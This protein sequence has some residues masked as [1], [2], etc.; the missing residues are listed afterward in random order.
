MRA[1]LWRLCLALL[2]TAAP[3][4][5]QEQRGS[6]EG[7]V[8]DSSG[9]VLPGVTVEAR[10]TTSGGAQTAV[11]DENGIY[12]FAA[13]APGLYDVRASLDSFNPAENKGVRLE[14]GQLLRVNLSLAVKGVQESVQVSAEQPLIDVKQNAKATVVDST[15]IDKMPTGRNFPDVVFAAAGAQDEDRAG[16]IQIDGASGSENRFMIDGLDTTNLQTGVSGK[17]LR[18]DFVQEVQVKTSGYNAE[19]RAAT[20]GVISA[21]TKSGSNQWHGGAS[22]YF[23]DADWF[24]DVR[25]TLRLN[26]IDTRQAETVFIPADDHTDSE[27][28]FDIGGPIFRDRA[29]FFLGGYQFNNI[30]KRTVRFTQRNPNNESRT[31]E[32][33]DRTNNYLGNISTQLTNELRGKF[34]FNVGR[35]RNGLALPGI[36]PNGTST[37][38]PD[39]FP[40]TKHLESYN[41][42]YSGTLDWV[43]SSKLYFNVTA[44]YNRYGDEEQGLFGTTLRREFASDNSMFPEI[45]ANLRQPNGYA[46]A[47]DV[48]RISADNWSRWQF[49]S[50]ATYY[51]NWMGQHTL[52]GGVQY[53]RITNDVNRG[54][55]FPRIILNWN[56]AFQSFDQGPL[57]GPYGHYTVRV[58]TTV[59]QITG[60]NVA[61]FIQDGW[62]VND[63]LTMN[64]GLRIEKEEVPSYRPENPGI[65][66]GWGDKITPRVGF[67]YDL[68]GDGR[69]KL[70]GSWGVFHDVMKLELPRGSFGANRWVDYY[71][72]L[73][74]FD[75]PSINCGYPPAPGTAGCPGTLLGSIDFRDVSNRDGASQ[76]DP[77]LKPMRS[78]EFTV[79]YDRELGHSMSVG[80][81][82]VRK[83]INRAIEDVGVIERGVERFFIANPGYGL[84]EFTIGPEFPAQ[85]PAQRDYDGLEF[86]LRKRWADRWQLNAVYTFSRLY[87]NYPGL[88]SSD[89]PNADGVGRRAPN[90]N[91]A[92]DGIYNSFDGN[93]N[94]V[95]GRLGS[96]RPHIF[97]VQGSYDLPW[98]TSVGLTQFVETG[99][100]ITR[101][102][103]NQGI[104]VFYMG[105][106]SDGRTPV[107]AQ[108]DLQLQQDVRLRSLR[109]AV[110]GEIFNVFDSDTAIRY[111]VVQYRD[112]VNAASNAAFFQGYDPQ[113]IAAAN[114]SIRPDARFLQPNTFQGRRAVRLGL[115][116][117]F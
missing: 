19:Y 52:K 22:Y 49:N 27:P 44:G 34:S 16:G 93:G 21:V 17:G 6:I 30:D 113:A 7:I 81:R 117:R 28:L 47:L 83:W 1:V 79:G 65:E 39:L 87:G 29:W 102:T 12:R 38:N 40:A 94:P 82:Y 14:L 116:F 99:T 114:P 2:L 109:F 111:H 78:Q 95:F 51:G 104:P 72:S 5:A 91:R 54:D 92:F 10:N 76:V 89:E 43:P 115:Q 59:G 62:T 90:V 33:K 101:E 8:K 70:Y 31:F 86:Q 71:V 69:N 11:S 74:T 32:D 20:G 50:D 85:P 73:D 45:P 98:G 41:D 4:I 26:P 97:K 48:A 66:F 112:R 64:L 75:W 18:T 53:E 106:G 42:I 25:P 107:L 15:F 84:A 80:V 108:T 55:Q 56:A 24:G 23:R 3:A 105:R 61:F 88:A 63:R 37:A 103:S 77:N 46:D 36:E 67:A 9:A 58:N 68:K 100:P 57:R 96:D 35:T 110:V 60:D 13:L